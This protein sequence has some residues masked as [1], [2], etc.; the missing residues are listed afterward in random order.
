MPAQP[1]R[2]TGWGTSGRVEGLARGSASPASCTGLGGPGQTR[3][4]ISGAGGQKPPEGVRQGE[5]VESRRG[6]DGP[7]TAQGP[8]RQGSLTPAASEL[9]PCLPLPFLRALGS[10]WSSLISVV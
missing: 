6:A 2:R 8:P 5:S 1:L 9:Q 3:C 4:P 10:R 7:V